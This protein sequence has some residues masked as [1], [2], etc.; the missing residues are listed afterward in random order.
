MENNKF[1]RLVDQKWE[2]VEITIRN[3]FFFCLRYVFT[4]FYIGSFQVPPKKN[5]PHL[6]CQFPLKIPTLP[7]SLLYERFEKWLSPLP[8]PSPRGAGGRTMFLCTLFK[9]DPHSYFPVNLASFFR[10]V[11]LKENLWTAFVRKN[12]RETVSHQAQFL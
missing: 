11:F 1:V 8:H 12:L 2:I 7:K 3:L 9:N 4:I 10:I 6:N 5:H